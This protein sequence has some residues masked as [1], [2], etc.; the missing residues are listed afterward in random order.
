MPRIIDIEAFTTI[1]ERHVRSGQQSQDRVRTSVVGR[2]DELTWLAVADGCSGSFY[3]GR[4]AQDLLQLVAEILRN[5]PAGVADIAE[6]ETLLVDGLSRMRYPEPMDFCSTLVLAQVQGGVAQ[7]H[8][9]GDGSLLTQDADGVW[10]EHEVSY[11]RGYPRFLHYFARNK[12]GKRRAIP[13]TDDW[14]DPLPPPRQVCSITQREWNDFG[15]KIVNKADF[16]QAQPLA[17]TLDVAQL[18]LLS[19]AVC[20][21]GALDPDCTFAE[22]IRSTPHG[23]SVTKRL[24]SAARQADFVPPE[25][26]ATLAIAHFAP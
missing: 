21:D 25:D 2:D 24:E 19:L 11:S 22:V 5:R 13:G 3:G 7:V 10:R 12:D 26:D 18:D 6:M 9:F 15:L 20:T 1:G 17:L 8:F 14:L 23:S 16:T 4:G